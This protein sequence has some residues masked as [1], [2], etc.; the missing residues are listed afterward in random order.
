V[1]YP[2]ASFVKFS[3]FCLISKRI[4]AMTGVEEGGFVRFCIHVGCDAGCT[5]VLIVIIIVGMCFI[6]IGKVMGKDAR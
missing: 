1:Q 4:I 3:I 2:L 6:V 5:L